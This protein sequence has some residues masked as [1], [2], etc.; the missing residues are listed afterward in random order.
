MCASNRLMPFPETFL[1]FFVAKGT[2]TITATSAKNL[3]VRSENLPLSCTQK[4]IFLT[5]QHHRQTCVVEC[6]SPDFTLAPCA[7]CAAVSHFYVLSLLSTFPVLNVT[8]LEQ[9]TKPIRIAE[10]TSKSD[11]ATIQGIHPANKTYKLELTSF[12]QSKAL[13][14]RHMRKSGKGAKK[15]STN[16]H[17][18]CT[19]T[20]EL[21]VM[22][23]VVAVEKIVQESSE[24]PCKLIGGGDDGGCCWCG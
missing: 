8:D 15:S 14:Y 22:V 4:I 13:L 21:A 2:T 18:G 3:F 5:H 7:I 24:N 9:A 6:L 12:P 1:S 23:E 10:W 11:T 20:G 16:Y 19:C 17:N